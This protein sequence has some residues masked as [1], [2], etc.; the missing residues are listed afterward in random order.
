[1]DNDD[2]DDSIDN[3]DK[4]KT[5]M[6]PVIDKLRGQFKRSV[7]N[8]G[9]KLEKLKQEQQS[10]IIRKFNSEM[11]KMKKRLEEQKSFKGD[12]EGDLKER[13]NEMQHNLE[14]ITSIA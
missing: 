9:P 2:E 14:L 10:D 12:Q 8:I 1:L 13:E 5:K 3:P 4:P 7:D 6:H 11:L